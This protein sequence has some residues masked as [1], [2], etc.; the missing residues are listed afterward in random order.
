MEVGIVICRLKGGEIFVVLVDLSNQEIK[1]CRRAVASTL[2]TMITTLLYYK[3][4]L[5]KCALRS[6]H[7]QLQQV[8]YA[9]QVVVAVVVL[10]G[11][12][13]VHNGGF[14]ALHHCE[15]L[16]KKN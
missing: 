12:R 14:A 16:L 3:Y 13:A 8:H 1:S 10:S 7:Q 6:Q 9:I 15:V 4:V 5:L 2:Y 11:R